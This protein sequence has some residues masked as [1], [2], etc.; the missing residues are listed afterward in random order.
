MGLIYRVDM[1]YFK[2][3]YSQNRYRNP[4]QGGRL[5]TV[6]R[7]TASIFGAAPEL[8]IDE[9]DIIRLVNEINK[10]ASDLTPS[11]RRRFL[12]RAARPIRQRA[13][14]LAPR[15]VKK[16]Y[17]YTTPKL[18][19]GKRA[20]RGSAIDYRLTY[21]PGNLSKSIKVL[22]FPRA[23]NAVFVGPKRFFKLSQKEYGR[24]IGTSDGYY[25]QMVYG[26]ADG[27]RN[28]VTAAALASVRPQVVAILQDQLN[29]YVKSVKAKTGL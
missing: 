21:H 25:A 26:S 24:T 5:R 10:V 2:S 1:G 27:F 7:Q 6:E 18:F 19:K 20:K 12:E 23:K 14:S 22:T 17:R 13:I 15:G 4:Y 28:R 11:K 3:L 29:K 16:H 9:V 8:F